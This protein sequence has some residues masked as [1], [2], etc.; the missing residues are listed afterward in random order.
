MSVKP[1]LF[2]GPMVQALLDRRKTQTRRVINPQPSTGM[3]FE[4]LDGY[5][6]HWI[7][8][9]HEGEINHEHKIPYA[10]DDLLYV[11][12]AWGCGSIYDK[13]K[14]S[15]I[16]VGEYPQGVRYPANE[17]F[18]G[19]RKRPGIHMPRAFSRLTLK[20]TEV[21]VQRLNEISNDDAA[22]EGVERVKSLLNQ[23]QFHHAGKNWD[24]PWPAFKSLWDSLNDTPRKRSDGTLGPDI[25]WDANPWVA[26]YTFK[27]IRGNVD[28][29]PQLEAA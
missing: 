15:L 25:S 17:Q 3:H 29:L 8:N 7:G 20:V 14:P 19:I 2:S 6:S 26:A 28:Q 11:R 16:P 23:N 24:L 4:E 9:S 1:I 27:V 10:V 13:V 18:L 22:D 21:R 12:E 5:T